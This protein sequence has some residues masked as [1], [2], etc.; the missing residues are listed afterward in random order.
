[1]IEVLADGGTLVDEVDGGAVDEETSH[2][3]ELI[4][5]LYEECLRIVAAEQ[6][7]AVDHEQNL[8][9]LPGSSHGFGGGLNQVIERLREI[10][11]VVLKGAPQLLLVRGVRLEYVA[12]IGEQ[13]AGEWKPPRR[14]APPI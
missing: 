1:M 7:G 6:I 14:F 3:L 8:V 2:L 10:G 13:L 5:V 11:E 9:S 4:Y 12:D